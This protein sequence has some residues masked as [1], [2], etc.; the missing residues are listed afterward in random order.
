MFCVKCG[1]ALSKE[2]EIQEKQETVTEVMEEENTE[3]MDETFCEEEVK[4]IVDEANKDTNIN[5]M[6][7]EETIV[8]NVAATPVSEPVAR[9]IRGF[10]G[11]KFSLSF[12]MIIFTVLSAATM[13]VDMFIVHYEKSAANEYDHF[14]YIRGTDIF[15]MLNEFGNVSENIKIF[16]I[17]S[18]VC[19][20]LVTAIA[21]VQ[22]FVILL[23]R[24]KG[25]Y[26]FVMLMSL[27]TIAIEVFMTVVFY[28]N[29]IVEQYDAVGLVGYGPV[30]AAVLNLSVIILA[31]VCRKVT[32]LNS[33]LN[34]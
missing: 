34:K 25:G 22:L 17:V 11:I 26:V 2:Q 10:G 15:K 14:D 23:W 5:D 29:Y 32:K 7:K 12:L 27:F 16:T 24:T 4:E 30:I 28:N 9:K 13:L 21:L 33:R 20:L 1:I 3:A 8:S 31:S 18:I 6:P 19:M